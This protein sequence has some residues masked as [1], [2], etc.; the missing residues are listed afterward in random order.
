MSEKTELTFIAMGVANPEVLVEFGPRENM[1]TSRVN[2]EMARAVMSLYTGD[3]DV[4]WESVIAE[5][6]CYAN[7][8]AVAANAAEAQT[9]P[10]HAASYAKY[11]ER[12]ISDATKRHALIS[13]KKV[14]QV[15]ED[16]MWEMDE[17]RNLAQKMFS[18]LAIQDDKKRTVS[19]YESAKE[20]EREILEAMAGNTNFI[21]TGFPRLDKALGGGMVRSE[22]T[23]VAAASSMGK[24]AFATQIGK[25][26]QSQGKCVM[27]FSMEMNHQANTKRFLA[28][29]LGLSIESQ[30]TGRIDERTMERIKQY[31]ESLKNSKFFVNDVR[32]MTLSEMRNQC[33]KVAMANG[34]IDL[35]IVDYI[36]LMNIETKGGSTS[37]DLANISRGLGQLAQDMK[38]HLILLCQINRKNEERSDP[39]PRISDLRDSGSIGN[40]ANN[41][42]FLHR[43]DYYDKNSKNPGV[44]EVIIQKN[45]QGMTG[46]IEL[47]FDGAR[48]LFTDVP[49]EDDCPFVAPDRKQFVPAS[50]TAVKSRLDDIFNR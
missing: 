46:T 48:F 30:N 15:L 38:A 2:W 37:Q 17:I 12:L 16:P 45:R 3:F 49:V 6:S 34:G 47:K 40:D 9:I 11:K 19:V 21:K 13:A 26:V 32:G 39:R 31:T 29:D 35:I 41:I 1:F 50:T 28:Q 14:L 20:V 44:T 4:C 8:Q 18:D 22:V 5:A 10:I 43:D 25:N 27:L 36:G 33:M 7:M 23:V 24:S 42:V